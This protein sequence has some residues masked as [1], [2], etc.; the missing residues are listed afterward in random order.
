[1]YGTLKK[2]HGN[3]SLLRTA[4]FIGEGV[5]ENPDYV[6]YD[7]PFPYVAFQYPG[8][9]IQGEVYEVDDG[10]LNRLDDLEGVDYDHYIKCR[11]SINVNGKSEECYIYLASE[12][13][14]KQINELYLKV[15]GGEV[16]SWR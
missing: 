3:H 13:T 7:G 9:R 5:T 1:V 12:K 16:L 4:R 10:T 11:V 2:G 14:K 6:M 15:I 8:K